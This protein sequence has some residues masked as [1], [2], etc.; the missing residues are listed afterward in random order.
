MSKII[1]ELSCVRVSTWLSEGSS[2]VAADSSPLSIIGGPILISIISASIGFGCSYRLN[3]LLG[4]RLILLDW[5]ANLLGDSLWLCGPDLDDLGDGGLLD[6]GL[7]D[8]RATESM[9]IEKDLS[10]G[11]ILVI[12]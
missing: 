12:N 6:G 1:L 9:G 5:G 7:L 3:H 8:G 2:S 10:G 4:W 11:L